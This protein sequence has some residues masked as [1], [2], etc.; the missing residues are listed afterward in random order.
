MSKKDKN[1]VP[2]LDAKKYGSCASFV[3]QTTPGQH[4]EGLD[5]EE[6]GTTPT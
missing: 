6:R 3:M 2:V 4:S 1:G 5:R